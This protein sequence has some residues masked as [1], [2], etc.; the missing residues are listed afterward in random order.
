[1]TP[2]QQLNRIVELLEQILTAQGQQPLPRP[3]PVTPARTAPY[4]EA[5]A[6][7]RSGDRAGAIAAGECCK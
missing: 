7:A 5:L 2:E 6:I 4:L 1:M 3:E